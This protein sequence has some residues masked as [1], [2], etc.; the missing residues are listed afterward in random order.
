M[1]VIDSKFEK[2]HI[3]LHHPSMRCEGMV[4][5]G[6]CPNLK[7]GDSDYCELHGANKNRIAQNTETQRNYRLAR[8]QQ[9]VGELADNDQIKSLREEIGILRMLMEEMLNKCEDQTDLLLYSH[10]ISDLAMKIERLVVSCDKL[11]SR[12]GLL[13]SKRAIL[14]L[15]GEYTQIIT[16][17]VTD[18]EVIEQIGSRLIE[19]TDRLD[20]LALESMET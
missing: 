7:S 15:A 2:W 18:P 14:Q 11:E 10:R 16:A 6:Q 13:L 19:V 12:M 17:Y 5:N 3:E 20:N 1:V 8:W 4:K 9:R